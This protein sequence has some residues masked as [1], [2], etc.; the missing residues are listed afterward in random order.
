MP[1]LGDFFTDE[2][3]DNYANNSIIKGAVLK[4]YVTKT[5]P[6]KEK[7]F[8]VLGEDNDDNYLGVVFINS[9]IN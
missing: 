4:F 6:P 9:E 5:K 8:V 7:R 2:F 1:H 3:K